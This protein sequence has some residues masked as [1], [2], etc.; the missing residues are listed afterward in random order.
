MLTF[1][2]LSFWA[3]PSRTSFCGLSCAA[4]GKIDCMAKWWAWQASQ[5]DLVCSDFC[6][7]G[8]AFQFVREKYQRYSFLFWVRFSKQMINAS[9]LLHK[10]CP[11][12]S[13]F[14][15][16]W[17]IEQLEVVFPSLSGIALVSHTPR[18]MK[19]FFDS[20]P[21]KTTAKY[22][23]HSIANSPSLS[24]LWNSQRFDLATRWARNGNFWKLRVN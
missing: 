8:N 2:L 12:P 24:R 6:V 3:R 1:P 14:L 17:F 10:Q 4:F 23:W 18:F 21:R 16:R 15:V 5:F 7:S 22:R 13:Q 19:T 20:H 11:L 9:R